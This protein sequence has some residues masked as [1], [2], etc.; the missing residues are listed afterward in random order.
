MCYADDRF[1]EQVVGEIYSLYGYMERVDSDFVNRVHETQREN[2]VDL[3]EISI[4]KFLYL[5]NLYPT[6]FLDKYRDKDFFLKDYE[7]FL[8]KDFNTTL[9]IINNKGEVTINKKTWR[10]ELRDFWTI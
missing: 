7:K 1:K 10:D 6:A 5:T 9:N 3:L 4:E 2:W 8:Y